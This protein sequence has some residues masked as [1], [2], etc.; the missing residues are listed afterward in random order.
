MWSHTM[1]SMPELQ[2]R[3]V[4]TTASKGR[5]FRRGSLR[6]RKLCSHPRCTAEPR[7]SFT[8]K[9]RRGWCW[10]TAWLFAGLCVAP[11]LGGSDSG[12]RLPLATANQQNRNL[13]TC[14]HWINGDQ[15]ISTKCFASDQP[16]CFRRNDD[17]GFG[18]IIFA[19]S[20]QYCDKLKQPHFKRNWNKK[21]QKW[22][23]AEKTSS[24]VR[25]QELKLFGLSW[26]T[27]MENFLT[28]SNY[29]M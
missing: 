29:I 28:I 11:T 20:M 6:I 27:A 25:V 5:R 24:A 18:Y 21:S 4:Q 7:R 2:K 12:K 16:S 13:P 23:R 26:R 17:N 9:A 22:L 14:C 19:I 15:H 10:S 3:A 8:S 1:H